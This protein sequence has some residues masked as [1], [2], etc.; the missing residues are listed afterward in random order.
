MGLEFLVPIFGILIVLVP[1]TGLTVVLT[2]RFASRPIVEAIMQLRGGQ[3][4]AGP[5]ETQ[6]QIQDL[7]ESVEA[8]TAEVQRLREAQAF[9]RKLLQ[10][11][12]GR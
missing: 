5:S 9:D 2:A 10:E 11:R 1:V 6:L 8:L 12:S 4:Y 3:G 7:S